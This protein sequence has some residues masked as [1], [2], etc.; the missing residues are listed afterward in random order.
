MKLV[1]H[2]HTPFL[3]V[4]LPENPIDFSRTLIYPCY[5]LRNGGCCFLDI[6]SIATLNTLHLDRVSKRLKG[7]KTRPTTASVDICQVTSQSHR[8][9]VHVFRPGR[10]MSSEGLS[11]G[12]KSMRMDA[13][14]K[15]Q[16]QRSCYNSREIYQ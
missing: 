7:T 14:G 12:L 11:R 9:P 8:H 10:T 13:K 4:A 3:V 5:G 16:V 2:C 15:N 6:Q 1:V